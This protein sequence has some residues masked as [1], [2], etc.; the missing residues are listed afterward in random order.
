[1]WKKIIIFALTTLILVGTLALLWP[2]FSDMAIE[3]KLQTIASDWIAEHPNISLP[4]YHID[5]FGSYYLG[6]ENGY[7]I[8]Y[9]NLGHEPGSIHVDV[10]MDATIKDS[11]KDELKKAAYTT[12][13]AGNVFYPAGEGELMVYCKNDPVV[14]TYNGN[15]ISYF[16]TLS[17]LYEA[18]KISKTA[19]DEAAKRFYDYMDIWDA[20]S[21]E[22]KYA[23]FKYIWYTK[24]SVDDSYRSESLRREFIRYRDRLEQDGL[25]I[26]D[27][28]DE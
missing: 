20:D 23:Y 15:K 21:D 4:W 19:V 13:I 14:L 10:S 8:F 7:D 26:P 2:V 12:E 28:V 22:I 5:G 16:Q 25:K 24:W 27:W 17:S 6:S 11:V 3:A 1:M 18:E 9:A